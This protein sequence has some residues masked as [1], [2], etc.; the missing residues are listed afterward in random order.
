MNTIKEDVLFHIMKKGKDI[1]NMLVDNLQAD[2]VTFAQNNGFVQEVKH[3]HLHVI[4][5]YKRK[6]VMSDE[7]V[8][9]KITAK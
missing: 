5:K 4:P 8:Y 9:K 7:E 1:A 6:M 3:Y 2:G